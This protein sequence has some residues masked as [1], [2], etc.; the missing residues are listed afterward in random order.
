ML[1]L[2]DLCVESGISIL[3]CLAVLDNNAQGIVFVVDNDRLLGSL[4]DGD[5]RRALINDANKNDLIE[6]YYNKKVVSFHMN[7]LDTEVQKTLSDKIKVIPLLD[8]G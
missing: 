6:G 2:E 7:A 5:I 3:D 8:A 1:R 4:T